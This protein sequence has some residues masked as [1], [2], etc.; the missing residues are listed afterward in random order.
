MK[1]LIKVPTKAEILER[2]QT[3]PVSHDGEP[4]KP[5]CLGRFADMSGVYVHCAGEKI[6]YV[7]KTTRGNYSTFGGRL[8]REFQK[9][10]SANSSL[11]RLLSSQKRI[12]TAFLPIE[13]VQKKTIAKRLTKDD[14]VLVFERALV[15]V[16]KPIANGAL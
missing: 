2:A 6:L 14:L 12:K 11:Y 9:K 8:R 3:I 16:Y 10:A 7:G 5:D 4:W 13:E 1:V 15:V